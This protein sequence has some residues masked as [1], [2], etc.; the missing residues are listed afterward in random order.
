MEK[1]VPS[2]S[3][4]RRATFIT[5]LKHNLPDSEILVLESRYV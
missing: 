2:L 5:N 1:I 3:D 4:L